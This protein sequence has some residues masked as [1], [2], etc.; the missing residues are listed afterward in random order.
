[1]TVYIEE[2]ENYVHD[3]SEIYA[4]KKKKK[5]DRHEKTLRFHLWLVSKL[6]VNKKLRFKAKL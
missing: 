2:L 4:Q 6:S 3:Q 1:M 5:K